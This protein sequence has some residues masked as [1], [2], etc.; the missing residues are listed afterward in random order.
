MIGCTKLLCGTATVS[1]ALRYDR[2]DSRE[3]PAD[4]LQFTS[5]KSPVVVWNVTGKC[6]LKCRHCYLDSDAQGFGEELSTKEAKSFIDNLSEMHIPV[7]LFS[8][9]EPLVRED[10]LELGNHASKRELR[11]V[12]STNGI[13]ID[14]HMALEIKKAGF[15]Y[16]GVSLDGLKK[17]HDRFRGEQGSWRKT[18]RGIE[19]LIKVGLK[20]GVRFTVTRD[21]IDELP[22]LIDL[23]V[24]KNVQ[25][26]C[27]YHLVYS[28]RGLD[29]ID[30]DLS[31]RQRIELI[32]LLIQKSIEHKDEIE[33]LSVDNPA[34]G[35]YLLNY[36]KENIPSRYNEVYRLLKRSGGC[37][38][39]EKIA[40]VDSQGRVHPCQFW[41][42]T[43]LGNVREK[44]FSE[45]WGNRL[46]IDPSEKNNKLKGKCGECEHKSLCRGCR[47]RAKVVYN[48]VW[49]EDPSC[50]LAEN[51]VEG[52]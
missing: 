24:E 18:W 45:I 16:V 46:I 19:N 17:T 23:C 2:V 29:L 15:V 12:L 40:A 13:L 51:T 38:A 4:I 1:D 3:I 31:S 49:Q 21:N 11:C 10:I 39:S 5:S 7:L 6:N 22:T 37:S 52:E 44:K 25:R 28:G 27:V 34:D 9:G 8:G 20:T 26:F 43:T 33:I 36:V 32:N 41:S 42:Y 30:I 50:Y 14:E 47:I 35:V 48:D